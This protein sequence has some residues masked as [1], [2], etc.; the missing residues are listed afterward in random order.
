[1]KFATGI[2]VTKL[3]K[4]KELNRD[5]TQ[6]EL[7]DLAESLLRHED[8][9]YNEYDEML[10]LISHEQFGRVLSKYKR[11]INRRFAG[12]KYEVNYI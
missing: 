4:T 7:F 6:T 10:E 3:S 9:D 12:V 2:K 1:M 8:I 11:A 5:E